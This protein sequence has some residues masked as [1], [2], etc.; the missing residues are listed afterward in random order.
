M[1]ITSEARCPYVKV[2]RARHSELWRLQYRMKYTMKYYRSVWVELWDVS[3]VAL[4][5]H[6]VVCLHQTQYGCLIFWSRRMDQRR[7]P[8]H[9]LH[10][11]SKIVSTVDILK[12]HR[13]N[14][15]ALLCF[16]LLCLW[17]L[18]YPSASIESN[19]LWF[20]MYPSASIESNLSMVLDVSLCIHWKQHID[21]DTLFER[22]LRLGGTHVN[23]I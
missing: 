21:N 8:L 4:H 10:G 11:W 22:T 7:V 12:C 5:R 16:A 9:H 14:I 1:S 3:Q 23:N 17:F 6:E 13:M 2:L 15:A 20:L 19:Y 18:M